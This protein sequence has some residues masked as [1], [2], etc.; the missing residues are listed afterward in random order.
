VTIG[1]IV[2]GGAARTIGGNSLAVVRIIRA[3]GE[4]TGHPIPARTL[5]ETPV[6]AEFTERV[7]R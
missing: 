4:V 2:A 1:G 6:L 5:F 7:F 3:V